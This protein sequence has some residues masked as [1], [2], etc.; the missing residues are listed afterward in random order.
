MKNL[1]SIF[2]CTLLESGHRD[3]GDLA[4]QAYCDL[5]LPAYIRYCQRGNPQGGI[6][7]KVPAA[8]SEEEWNKLVTLFVSQK[9][10]D[11]QKDAYQK[12]ESS[13]DKTGIFAPISS[14]KMRQR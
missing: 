12:N 13:Y 5:S 1:L 8:I 6:E 9:N 11:T 2:C 7:D 14:R 4:V 10:Q 3:C